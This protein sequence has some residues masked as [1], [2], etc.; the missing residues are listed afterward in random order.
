MREDRSGKFSK[1]PRTLRDGFLELQFALHT[2]PVYCVV[3]IDA[4][5]K[6]AETVVSYPKECLAADSN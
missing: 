3:F 2:N 6:I 1:L 5:S 4:F